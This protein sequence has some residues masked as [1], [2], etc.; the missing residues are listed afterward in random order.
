MARNPWLNIAIAIVKHVGLIVNSACKID[1]LLYL[2][3]VEA[4]GVVNS[5]AQ[6]C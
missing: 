4:Q 1:I 2:L 6:I 5:C 3:A